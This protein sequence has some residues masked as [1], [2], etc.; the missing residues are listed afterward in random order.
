MCQRLYDE[1]NQHKQD[2]VL[3]LSEANSKLADLQSQEED[4]EYEL[5]QKG[6]EL[7]EI[8]ARKQNLQ[9]QYDEIQEKIFDKTNEKNQKIN[10][11]SD[12]ERRKKIIKDELT[13]LKNRANVLYKLIQTPEPEPVYRQQTFRI[14]AKGNIV[15]GRQIGGYTILS[16]NQVTVN[17]N[18]IENHRESVESAIA[19]KG[20]ID[21]KIIKLQNE[22][23]SLEEKTYIL[24][25]DISA[26]DYLLLDLKSEQLKISQKIDENQRYYEEQK[27]EYENLIIQKNNLHAQVEAAKSLVEEAKTAIDDANFRLELSQQDL[28]QKE[29][30]LAE[31]EQQLTHISAQLKHNQEVD[32]EQTRQRETQRTEQER[33]NR[34]NITYADLVRLANQRLDAERNEKREQVTREDLEELANRRLAGKDNQ[35]PSRRVTM[36]DLEELARQ[37]LDAADAAVEDAI[38]SAPIDKMTKAE[39][40]YLKNGFG[41]FLQ[42]KTTET[43]NNIDE[44]TENNSNQY[45]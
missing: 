17:R 7:K 14:P 11:L 31:A 19:E 30:E 5:E 39:L 32:L 21:D 6:K 23:G 38:N 29:V 16:S 28:N 42:H 10:L 15:G 34:A 22:Y 40:K 35:A 13:A 25:S 3:N 8:E 12:I 33:Q 36:E 1:D 26:L 4:K 41:R 24:K 2:A 45:K 44:I 9:K 43:V 18:E 20:K 37:R 27:I